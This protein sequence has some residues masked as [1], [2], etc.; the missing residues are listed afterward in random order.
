MKG[1]RILVGCITEEFHLDDNDAENIVEV[2]VAAIRTA[3][4][5]YLS[6]NRMVWAGDYMGVSRN[7]FGAYA[8]VDTFDD[9]F[10]WAFTSRGNWDES[11]EEYETEDAAKA[12]AYDDLCQKIK[13]MF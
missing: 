8:I 5:D 7:P 1:N 13:E 11:D 3:P 9:K 6:P 2:L 10:R 12:A 4:L